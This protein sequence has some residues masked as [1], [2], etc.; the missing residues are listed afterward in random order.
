MWVVTPV[1]RRACVVSCRFPSPRTF[2]LCATSLDMLPIR[3]A[4]S[5]RT[6]RPL[7]RSLELTL[8]RSLSHSA[9]QHPTFPLSPALPARLP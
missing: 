4:S 3:H 2:R 5:F 6:A 8:S 7:A 1:C 9:F